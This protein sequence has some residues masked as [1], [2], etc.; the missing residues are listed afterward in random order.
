MHVSAVLL[1]QQ[2]TD[3]EKNCWDASADERKSRSS[4][5]IWQKLWWKLKKLRKTNQQNSFFWILLQLSYLKKKN[6]NLWN[7]PGQRW[8]YLWGNSCN[9]TIF[10][11]FN[12][13]VWD[14]RFH[15]DFYYCKL[16]SHKTSERM[17]KIRQSWIVCFANINEHSGGVFF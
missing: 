1:M 6:T 5:K 12:E 14:R 4:Y 11:T 8:H 3:V 13:T 9:Q 16:T 7:G 2:F 17:R 10:G 15:W